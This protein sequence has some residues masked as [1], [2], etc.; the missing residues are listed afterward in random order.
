MDLLPA[1]RRL[2]PRRANLLSE[3][4]RRQVA[5]AILL[6]SGARVLLLDE[7]TTGLSEENTAQLIMAIRTHCREVSGAAV[8]I[9]HRPETLERA[10][11]RVLFM[12]GGRIVEEI[13]GESTDLSRRLVQLYFA[14]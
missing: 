7:A 3:G 12:S 2:L 14:Q 8:I 13:P 5:V 10:C 1:L 4:E 6:V 9:E 11:A